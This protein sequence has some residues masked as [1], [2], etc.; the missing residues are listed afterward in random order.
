MITGF[1]T[2]V[3]LMACLMIFPIT[4][5]YGQ[6]AAAGPGLVFMSMPLAFAEI[7]AGGML[8]AIMFFGLL[9]F[10]ALTSA[11]S[12]RATGPLSHADPSNSFTPIGLVPISA[13]FSLVGT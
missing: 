7:G 1:D 12:L 13:G 11:I 10:A 2:M 4:F 5:S 8:L 6:E 9:V 3:A